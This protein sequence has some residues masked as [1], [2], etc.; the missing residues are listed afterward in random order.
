MKKIF[1]LLLTISLGLFA[2][3]QNPVSWAFSSKKIKDGVYELQFS[4]S[5]QGGWHLYSQ[6]QPSDA[7]AQPTAFTFN[8]NPLINWEGKVKEIGNLEKYHDKTLDVSA[9]QFSNKVVFVQ[10]V[11]LK[12]KAKT[13][14]SGSVEYQTCNDEK[15]LPPKTIPFTIALN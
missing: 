4:A 15:C 9:N 10:V 13:A 12:A 3:A 14:V 6:K 5:I 2:A 8:K 11:K 1:L 7:I